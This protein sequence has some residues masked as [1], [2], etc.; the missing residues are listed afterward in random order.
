M[1]IVDNNI[2]TVTCNSCDITVT[3]DVKDPKVTQENPWLN[4]VRIVQVIASGRNFAYCS[5]QCM[6]AGIAA[7]E[8]NPP[9][10]KKIVEVADGQSNAAILMAA[11]AAKA[12]ESATKAIKDGKPAKL[13]VVKG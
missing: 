10:Q 13:Q 5:D 11:N 8:L 4:N 6:I 3:F 12:A 7:G 2:R 1:S 9:E